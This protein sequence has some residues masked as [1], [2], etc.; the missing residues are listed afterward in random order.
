MA[1]MKTHKFS[2]G[3]NTQKM[4]E[5]YEELKGKNSSKKEAPFEKIKNM[6]SRAK[7]AVSDAMA[8]DD[9]KIAKRG[10]EILASANP[11][12]GSYQ[13]PAYL[14]E[15]GIN[16]L[17]TEGLGRGRNTGE[18]TNP[19][20]DAYKKGG[21]VGSASKRADGIAQRGKTKGTTVVMC[22]G[23]YAKKGK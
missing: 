9:A 2:Q 11:V 10:L 23:G 5:E 17:R 12:L 15:K 8:S 20:G 1:K 14:A 4:D 6:A 19:M 18:T 22:G 7:S 13:V 16:A 3:G 21:K